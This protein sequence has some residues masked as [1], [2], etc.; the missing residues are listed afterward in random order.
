MPT[1]VRSKGFIALA[2]L[3]A[4]ILFVVFVIV[5]IIWS[6]YYGFF[7]WKGIGATKFIGLDNYREIL[8]DHIFW[9]ALKNNMILIVSAIVGQV[10]IALILAIVL[11]KN[12]FFS[13]FVRSAVFMPMVLSTVVVG[14][15]WGYIY[16]PQF[17]LVNTILEAVGLESWSRAWLSDVKVNMFA[18]T[19]PINWSNI[20]PYMIIFIAALQ[21]IS[22]EIDD[23]ANIDG[24]QKG[25]KLF[26]VTLPMIWSTVVVTLVLC[27]S[28]SLK[29]FDHVMVMTHGGPAQSTELLATYMYNNTFR[30]YRYGYGSA[31][32]TIIMIISALLIGINYILTRK[33]AD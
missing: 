10:P 17:G 9:R 12:S 28:G 5:P 7:E 4:L 8:Q 2:L 22:P 31:V 25:K 26:Y 1:A 30:V 18:I 6:A 20:G 3:P 14:L 29:A 16:N 32:S 27:I 21:N 19:I 15:I 23:A 13:R 33:K 11:L 24:A